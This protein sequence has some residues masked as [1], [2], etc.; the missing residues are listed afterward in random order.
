M[1]LSA[2][3][4]SLMAVMGPAGSVLAQ[5]A[6]EARRCF[7]PAETRERIRVDKLIEPIFVVRSTAGAIQADALSAKLCRVDGVFVYEV[8][9]LRRDGRVTHVTIDATTGVPKVRGA[10][11]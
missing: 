8:D 2:A 4:L 9:F 11:R 6:P 10:P 1:V 5:P 3:L 7:S